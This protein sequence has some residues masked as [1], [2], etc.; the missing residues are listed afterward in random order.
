MNTTEV[1]AAAALM[2]VMGIRMEQFAAIKL[3]VSRRNVI[4]V[5]TVG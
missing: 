1:I 3:M 2:D 4:E 5:P